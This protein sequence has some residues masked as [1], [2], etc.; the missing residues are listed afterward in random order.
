MRAAASFVTMPPELDPRRCS[1]RHRLDLGGDLAQDRNMRGLGI[2]ARI[3]GVKP[4][5]IG[6]QH[7]RVGADHLRHARGKP[8]VIAKTYLRRRHR[9]VL[10]D[11]R[12]RLEEQQLLDG[13]ARV[14][15][16]APLLGI[17]GGE[18]NLRHR[19]AVLGRHLLIG[20]GETDLPSGGSGLFFL[21]P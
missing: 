13:R 7:Q 18:K 5:D 15:M 17:V 21:E 4:V 11:D 19:D 3:G 9:V 14:Q 2:V 12:Q 1:A 16:P 8:V 20:M 6:E 10:V